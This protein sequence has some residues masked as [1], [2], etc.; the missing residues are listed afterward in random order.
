MKLLLAFI[1]LALACAA[2]AATWT[3]RSGE[4]I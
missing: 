3:V 2:Q 4:A 1:A